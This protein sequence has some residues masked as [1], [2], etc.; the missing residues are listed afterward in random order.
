MK[1]RLVTLM[2]ALCLAC[3][4]VIPV[5]ASALEQEQEDLNLSDLMITQVDVTFDNESLE[6]MGRISTKDAV[7]INGVVN[8][9]YP[10]FCKE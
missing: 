3:T 1:K 9:L 5:G 10:T 6:D 7:V 8:Y 2:M 4:L